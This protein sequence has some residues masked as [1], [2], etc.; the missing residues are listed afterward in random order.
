MEIN[1]SLVL[2]EQKQRIVIRLPGLGNHLLRDTSMAVGLLF[3]FQKLLSIIRDFKPQLITIPSTD[4][5]YESIEAAT[6]PFLPLSFS[7]EH[8][9]RFSKSFK[10]LFLRSGRNL[11]LIILY[12]V[13]LTTSDDKRWKQINVKLRID[14]ATVRSDHLTSSSIKSNGMFLLRNRIFWNLY[15]TE[16]ILTRF[17]SRDKRSKVIS[18]KQQVD[19]EWVEYRNSTGEFWISYESSLLC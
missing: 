11:N 14:T 19:D 2:H 8:E 3:S 17:V 15:S 9:K 18:M 12:F 1:F 16:W 5:S 4:M 7:I 13:F 6:K 10:I